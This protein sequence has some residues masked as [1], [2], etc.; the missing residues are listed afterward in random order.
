MTVEQV[1]ERLRE[2]LAMPQLKLPIKEKEYAE[3]E[4]QQLKEDLVAYYRDYVD[5]F[6]N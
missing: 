6:E 1:L 5:N 4:Y 3:E 2:E